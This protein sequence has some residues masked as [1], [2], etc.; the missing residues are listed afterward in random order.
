VI[1]RGRTLA[2]L[3]VVLA[4]GLATRRVSALPDVVEDHAGDA[5]WATAVV[6]GLAVVWPARR[7][8]EL[9]LAGFVIALSVEL[10]QL[11][12][13]S[14][15]EELRENDAAALVLGRGFL[16]GDIPRYAVGCLLGVACLSALTGST[17]SRLQP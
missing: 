11:W 14:W 3:V 12:H 7:P 6:L 8:T 2:A 17:R 16:W 15:L 4:V 1:P 5:L 13:A 9:G 10:S